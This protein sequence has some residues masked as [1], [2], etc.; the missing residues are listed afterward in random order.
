MP[1][2]IQIGFEMSVEKVYKQSD[3]QTNRHF[4]IYICRDCP[5]FCYDLLKKIIQDVLKFGIVGEPIYMIMKF[6]V[7]IFLRFL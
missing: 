1:K 4:R 3:R 2:G 7:Q 6:I 5:I